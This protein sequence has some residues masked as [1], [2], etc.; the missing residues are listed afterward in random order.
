MSLLIFGSTGTLG[1][2][3]TRRAIDE[4]YIVKCFVRNLRKAYFLKEWGAELIYGDLSLPETIPLCLRDIS[5]IIDASTSR[6]SDPYDAECVDLD[7]KIALIEAAKIAGIKKFIFFSVLN[8]TY[9]SHVPLISLKLKI[10]DYLIQSNLNYTIFC[11]GGFFQGL[12]GQYAIP[13][14]EKQPIW[15][16]NETSRVNYIDTQ[17]VAKFTLRSLSVADTTKRRFPLVG[18]KS[19]NSQEI[20]ELC[21]RLSG[22]PAFVNKVPL[23]ILQF[24]RALTGFFEWGKNISDRLSFAEVLVTGPDM[25]ADMSEVYR[26]LSL[27]PSDTST[28]ERYFQDYFGRILKRLK[29][30]N[31]EKEKT[32]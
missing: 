6:P 32:L 16:A 18:V 22:Q 4:G 24:L 3:I 29:E 31:D 1:R 14:L 30:L 13:I 17:D 11:L 2:Q 27:D 9:H 5:A 15:T 20:V 26:I 10:E 23:Q 7:G 19:W 8:G 12:I 25:T 21:E 28:L